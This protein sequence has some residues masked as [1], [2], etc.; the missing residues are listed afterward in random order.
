MNKVTQV[1]D[2]LADERGEEPQLPN[3]TQQKFQKVGRLS[4]RQFNACYFYSYYD[5]PYFSES[6]LYQMMDRLGL[7]LSAK[8]NKFEWAFIR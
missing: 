4:K 2:L 1:I 8:F 5:R 6:L 7:P 3:Q